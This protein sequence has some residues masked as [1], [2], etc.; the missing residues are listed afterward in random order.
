L[1]T[2]KHIKMLLRPELRSEPQWGSSQRS[3]RRPILAELG[4]HF[5]AERER[6]DKKGGKG[7]KRR[8]RKA[9]RGNWPQ[10]G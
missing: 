1:L 6:E 5:S 8:L 2:S 4:G 10:K 3:I 7:M 9:R